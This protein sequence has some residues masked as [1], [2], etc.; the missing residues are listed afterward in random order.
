MGECLRKAC[1]C[2]DQLWQRIFGDKKPAAGGVNVGNEAG[3]GGTGGVEEE[4]PS[5]SPSPSPASSVHERGPEIGSIYTAIWGFESRHKDELSF[6]EGD[7]FS[8]ISRTG[9][10]WTARK[11][12]KNGCVLST[13]IVPNNYLARAESLEIQPWFFGRM[14]RFEA[15]SHLLAPGNDHAA[16][17]IRQSEKD[18]IGYVL[19]VR[20][21]DRVKHFK[22]LQGNENDF[23]VEPNRFFRSLIDLVEF[24]CAN[25][26]N[27]AHK[28]GNPCKRKKPT[29]PDLSHFTVDEWEL[30]KEE[31]SLEEQ[32]G[33]GYFADVYRGRWKN[34]IKVAIKILKSDSELNHREFHREVQILKSLRHRHLISLFAVCTAAPPYYIITELM[35]KGS[36]LSFLRGPEGQKQDVASL[37]DMGA[38]VADG[39]SYLEEKNSIHRDLAAR[40]V[41][42]GED[43]ICKVADFGLARVIKEP[44]YITEDKKIPYK[45]SAP[46]A[47]SHGKFSNK[48]D[49]WSFGVLLYEITT[50]GGIPYPALSN[51]EA[52]QQVSS[53][54]R[55][56][57]PA[58]CPAFLYQIML[59]CWSA[60][61]ADR[62]DFKSL[63]V[64]M[65][66]S[67]YELD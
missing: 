8:V 1:P 23:Y 29:T 4:T 43:Y 20:S 9:D 32:L 12:D 30:P 52:Y 5:P 26:L 57:A 16:F 35:E 55:L 27:T 63:K 6:Q 67:S 33:S 61:P 39:M 58:K 41:L 3:T 56:P 49:V 59:K 36:L 2:L 47:I 13:G 15:Q 40:N 54:Y 37:I 64:H 44:F 60:D 46:E 45:W 51:Q 17:L 50:Y 19:S 31:F 53:G 62:P 25:S 28:L 24:Y 21:N 42:V 10:W 11:I 65:D 7:L 34:M 66:S 22:V 18:D 38:Q 14:N 48:S